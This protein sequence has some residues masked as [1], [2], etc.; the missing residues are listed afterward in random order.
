[1]NIDGNDIARR[2]RDMG[3]HHHAAVVEEATEMVA[4]GQPLDR[5]TIT[6][7][8][9]AVSNLKSVHGEAVATL[10]IDLLTFIEHNK[11]K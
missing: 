5:T 1:M 10:G 8:D 9:S 7:L 4:A 11:P 3:E 6:A 2:L